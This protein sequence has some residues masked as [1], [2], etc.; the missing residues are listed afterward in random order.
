MGSSLTTPANRIAPLRA[1]ATALVLGSGGLLVL[2]GSLGESREWAFAGLAATVAGI[3]TSVGFAIRARTEPRSGSGRNASPD[4]RRRRGALIGAL[5]MRLTSGG[6]MFAA[7]YL[8]SSNGWH[9]AGL[10][11]AVGGAV[12]AAAYRLDRYARSA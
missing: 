7:G 6:I 2:A 9:V 3:A 10:L 5:V 4:G 1:A 11:A 8:G 12:V